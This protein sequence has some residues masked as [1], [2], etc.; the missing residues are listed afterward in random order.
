MS[1]A[2]VGVMVWLEDGRDDGRGDGD[3]NCGQRWFTTSGGRR[4][5][6]VYGEGWSKA[7]DGLREMVIYGEWWPASKQWSK[8]KGGLW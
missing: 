2:E 8:A 6:E 3:R 1:T 7:N 4:Q 5:I